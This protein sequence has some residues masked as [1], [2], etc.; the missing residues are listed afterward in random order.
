GSGMDAIAVLNALASRLNREAGRPAIPWLYFFTDPVRTPDPVAIAQTLPRG[1]AVVVRHFGKPNRFVE[2]RR[3]AP[4]CPARG[5]VLLI[6]ADP[7]LAQ[8]VRADGV[9]WPEKLAPKRRGDL[10]LE[11]A[12]AHSR[13]ALVRASAAGFDAAI[14]SPIFAS[15]SPSAERPLG[16]VRAA[17]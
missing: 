9:H 10:P 3:L 5:L 7:E 11:T 1:A 6:A 4:P 13:R 12:A 16:T 17:A 14:F 2:A 8:R 15:R